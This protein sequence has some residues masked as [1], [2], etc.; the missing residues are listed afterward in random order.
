MR[1]HKDKKTKFELFNEKLQL[2]ELTQKGAHKDAR[3]P[4]M[5]E[6]DNNVQFTTKE[7]NKRYKT[8]TTDTS[9]I[10]NEARFITHTQEEN[11][12]KSTKLLEL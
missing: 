8:L 12:T 1:L 5:Y 9:D 3:M 11:N 2:H 6:I 7:I 10:D 4:P